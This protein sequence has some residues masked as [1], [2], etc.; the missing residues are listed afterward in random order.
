M[1]VTETTISVPSASKRAVTMSVVVR[2]IGAVIRL[3]YEVPER[4]RDRVPVGCDVCGA[5]A[6][7]ATEKLLDD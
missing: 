4:C 2:L 6:A 1:S 3:A 5:G 7:G